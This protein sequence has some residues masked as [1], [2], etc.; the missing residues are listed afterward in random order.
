VGGS[1]SPRGFALSLPRGRQIGITA[2]L[3]F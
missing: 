1:T 2:N 3:R